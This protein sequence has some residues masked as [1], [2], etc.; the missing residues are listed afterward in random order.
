MFSFQSVNAVYRITL[1][2]TSSVGY[3]TAFQSVP[4]QGVQEYDF[5]LSIVNSV[6]LDYEEVTWRNFSFQFFVQETVDPA[7][8]DTLTVKVQLTNWNDESP[9]F[10]QEEYVVQVNETIPINELFATVYAT[11][12]DVDDTVV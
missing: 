7:H 1:I 4:N 3:N 2:D 5:S 9:I 8:T 6:L 11:D 12:R 10:E